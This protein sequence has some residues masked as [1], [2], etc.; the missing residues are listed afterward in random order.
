MY[1]VRLLCVLCV[2]AVKCDELVSR[3]HTCEE[4]FWTAKH[5]VHRPRHMAQC[6]GTSSVSEPGAPPLPPGAYFTH[7]H[8]ACGSHMSQHV[9]GP[10]N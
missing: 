2:Q 1:T 3:N 4:L 6:A 9:S 10:Q 7:D 8:D 5:Q